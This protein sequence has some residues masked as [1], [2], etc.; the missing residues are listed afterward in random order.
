MFELAGPDARG[1]VG[2]QGVPARSWTV[3]PSSGWSV[4]QIEALE[5]AGVPV[6][7]V[8]A[9]DAH[10]RGAVSGGAVPDGA[11]AD[12]VARAGEGAGSWLDAVEAP[13]LGPVSW[14]TE[15]APSGGLLAD[16]ESMPAD[17]VVDDYDA[18][19]MVGLW[20]SMEAYCAAGKRRAAA[21][22]ARREA[23]AAGLAGVQGLGFTVADPNI[24]ADE[25]SLRLGISR[26]AAKRLVASGR[27]MGGAGI[28]TGE[29][30]ASGELDA[31]K[32][33]LILEAIAELG[34]DAALAVQDRVLPKARHLG[35]GR[36]R[37]ELAAAVAAVDPTDFEE[38]CAEAARSRRVDR[39]RALPN[40]MASLTA[41]LPAAEATQVY[42]TLDAA[43]R[44]AKTCGQETRTMDQLRA[45]ALALLAT[46][47]LATGWVGP[48][49]TAEP[50]DETQTRMRI[51][52]IGGMSAHIKVVVPYTT[53]MDGT[54]PPDP[55]PPDHHDGSGAG[56]LPARQVPVP[57]AL[58]FAE[59]EGYGPIPTAV[60]RALAA[61][62]STWA[63][64]VLDPI[65]RT[66]LEVSRKRYQPPESMARLVRA[67][68]PYCA[69]PSCS[70]ASD[71]ADLHHR[72]PW[73]VG[74]TSVWNLD[75]G[76]RRDHLLLTHAGWRYE[77]HEGPG[78]ART[79]TTATGHVYS[80]GLDDVV[81]M[82]GKHGPPPPSRTVRQRVSDQGDASPPF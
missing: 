3:E 22:L 16:V 17:L 78:N 1:G 15:R 79:W 69:Q 21:E 42:R 14:L 39:P 55:R 71:G 67:A 20:A 63:R 11:D 61:G 82:H 25:L 70:V 46:S 31:W 29:A 80:H 9:D 30:L 43:A 24:A 75:P 58:A 40:G 12:G 28:P 76:C 19:E 45:D 56:G 2:G 65:D 27:L 72:I 13:Q 54:G 47:A 52:R 38:R 51:G 32:A 34:A 10:L 48:A 26:R 66:V 4:E 68:Q 49:P 59:L 41:V 60:A 5:W 18:V 8:D 36:L 33:D 74:A 35:Q 77:Q 6:V 62:S 81:T 50:R 44:S 57:D 64:L 73:P 53:L 23:M 7:E 37:R